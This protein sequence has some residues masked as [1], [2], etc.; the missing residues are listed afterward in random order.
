MAS[1][2][3]DGRESFMRK[4]HDAVRCKAAERHAKAAAA[5]FIVGISK[6]LEGGGWGGGGGEGRGGKGSVRPKRLKSG[7]GH[8]RL[9]VCGPS[10]GRQDCVRPP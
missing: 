8:H 2:D 7:S 3:R 5:P 10:T 9:E 4:W 6:R 1:T